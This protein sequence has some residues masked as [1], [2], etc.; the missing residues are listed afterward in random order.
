MTLTAATRR[1][2]A[3]HIQV[4]EDEQFIPRHQHRKG[5]LILALHGA[6]TCEVES[7]MWMVPPQYAVWGTGPA[8]P[9]QPRDAGGA[10]LFFIYRAG[11]GPDA[12]A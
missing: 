1:P 4:V 8:A 3:F 11:S 9:Q 5:Q 12:A 2:L 7:G 10:D 6:L